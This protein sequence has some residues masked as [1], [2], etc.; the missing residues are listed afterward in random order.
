MKKMKA[1]A[2]CAVLG[3]CLL[4]SSCIGSFSAWNSLKDWN[5]GIG[6]KAVNEL[7]FLA[8]HII[9]VYEVAYLADVLVLN[10]IEFWSGSN[11][12]ADVGTE[13]V[14]HG[15]DGE[16]LVRTN[17]DGYTITKLD[18]VDHPLNLVYDAEKCTW[19][20]VAEGK[21][22]ELMTMNEDGTVTYK[23]QDGTSTTVMPE[24]L[25]ETVAV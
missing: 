8:F 19:N 18:E 14:I 9:P 2:V 7:V 20:V 25:K 13:K 11:P 12:M 21:T 16:Y 1:T 10:S 3:G 23:Q 24:W 22:Y 4:C 5:M 15:E 6:H 17:E